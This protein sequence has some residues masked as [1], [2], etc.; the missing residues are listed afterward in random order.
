MIFPN[1]CQPKIGF[2]WGCFRSLIWF[3]SRSVQFAIS[4]DSLVLFCAKRL[5]GSPPVFQPISS[6]LIIDSVAD[7]SRFFRNGAHSPNFLNFGFLGPNSPLSTVSDSIRLSA[8]LLFRTS[9]LT[10]IIGFLER[11]DHRLAIRLSQSRPASSSLSVSPHTHNQSTT[12]SSFYI[13]RASRKATSSAP[14]SD[15]HVLNLI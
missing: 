2:V 6:V 13:L 12:T 10:G 8:E 14:L 1:Y 9:Q 3:A 4:S 15:Q 5:F 7:Q 11:R